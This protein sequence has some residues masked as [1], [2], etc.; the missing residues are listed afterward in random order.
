MKKR[1]YVIIAIF[2]SFL[3]II[4]FLI[5]RFGSGLEKSNKITIWT[6][7][8]PEYDFTKAIVGDKMEVVRLI[9]PGI[10]IHTFEPSSKDMIR[11]ADS[12][13]FIY[14]G[15]SMEPWAKKI[16]D[17]VKDYD[18]KIVDTSKNI[19]MIEPDEFFDEYSLLDESHDEEHEHEEE[20]D[21][22]IWLNPQNAVIMIDTILEEIINLDPKNKEF[23]EENAEKYKNE[24][25]ELDKEIEEELKKNDV[26]VLV[27]GGEFAYSYFCQR[28]KLGVISCYTTCGEHSEPSVAR[29]KDVI[30][31]INKN[32][33][34][35]IYYE[36]LSEGQI[37]QMLSEETKAEAKVF[38]TLHNVSKEEIE[39]KENYISIM[40]ENL[41]KIIN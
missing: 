1:I 34:S 33:I 38:N 4:S 36:E 41:N 39:N 20:K 18:V 28:Y 12:Q 27:F 19:E 30:E 22:H 11:I 23:Y 6:T 3:A 35:S 17:S 8:Y 10:E 9:G 25:L 2:I 5:I 15:D 21:G 14:T 37:S 13:A 26:N 32:N 29:I 24:I 31:Y 16:I 7:I 40:K